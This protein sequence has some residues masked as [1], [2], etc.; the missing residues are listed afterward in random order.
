MVALSGV[1]ASFVSLT[2]VYIC[3]YIAAR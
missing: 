1:L 2:S 3:D